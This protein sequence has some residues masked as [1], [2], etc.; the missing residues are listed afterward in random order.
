L[1][2]FPFPASTDEQ[3]AKM[4]GFCTLVARNRASGFRSPSCCLGQQDCR[5][6]CGWVIAVC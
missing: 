2:P 6:F 5:A 1:I 4:R 3:W